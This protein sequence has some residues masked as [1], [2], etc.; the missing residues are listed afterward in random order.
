MPDITKALVKLATA[1]D[2]LAENLQRDAGEVLAAGKE[3]REAL[4]KKPGEDEGEE[5]K[6]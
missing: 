2:Q 6:D 1:I 5:K 3:I 4:P